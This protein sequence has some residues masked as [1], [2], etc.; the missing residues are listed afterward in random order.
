[1]QDFIELEV[2]NDVDHICKALDL[3]IEFRQNFQYKVTQLCDIEYTNRPIRDPKKAEEKFLKM[4]INSEK[5]IKLETNCTKTYPA[6]SKML[7]ERPKGANSK[8]NVAFRRA[9]RETDAIIQ[10]KEEKQK[11]EKVQRKKL[12]LEKKNLKKQSFIMV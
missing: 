1:M 4:C 8:E 5:I 10:A 3:A 11:Q 6:F 7:L 12:F 2:T 9:I